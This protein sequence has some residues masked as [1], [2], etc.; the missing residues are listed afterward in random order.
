M[1]FSL[2]DQYRTLHATKAYGATSARK[3]HYMIPHIRL[4]KPQS[5][6]DYGCGQSAL[7]DMIRSS[8]I[9]DVCRYDPAIQAF[10]ARPDMTFD[11]LIS[12]D[13]L[14]HVPEIE[15]DDVLADMRAMATHSMLI[16]DTK[17]A[18]TILP[19][20]ENAHATI[21]PPQ[22]W[23]DRL[24]RHYDFLETF[25]FPAKRARAC[26]KT[27]STP[28]AYRPL[29]WVESQYLRMRQRARAATVFKAD[30]K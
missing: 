22:W 17:P 6:I 1:T 25:Y 16:I 12:V 8:G 10:A 21:K 20:G 9:P 23:K 29:L 13:V 27:W 2:I 3:A 7:A 18:K 5:V 14:E 11:L 26:F 19:N 28:L 4:L 24:S 30:S 15:L